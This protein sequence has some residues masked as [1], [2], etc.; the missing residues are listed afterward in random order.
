MFCKLIRGLVCAVTLS[1][2]L[3]GHVLG[4]EVTVNQAVEY[5]TIDGFGAFGARNVNWSDPSTW[6]N[7]YWLDLVINDLGLTIHRNEYYPPGGDQDSSFAEQIAF[8]Q[9]L[10]Q[11]AQD[12]NEPLKFIVAFWSPPAWMKD[13]G[14][15]KN[16]GRVL[17]QYYDDLGNWAVTC[18][19]DY[20]SIGINVYALS[21]QNEPNFTQPYNSCVYSPQEYRDMVKVAG[22]IIKAAFPNVRLYGAEHMLWAMQW[23]ELNYESPIIADTNA[24]PYMGIWAN[25]G[26][27]NDGQTPDPNSAE[28]AAWVGAWNVV[29]NTG[30]PL[31]M[32]E[33][34]GYD[35]TWPNC[36]QLG[37]AIYA[38]LKCGRASG[39]VWWQLGEE[40]VSAYN[41]MNLDT[42]TKRYYV[43]KQYY[44]YV[45]PG[46]VVVESTSDD[47][48]V[49][50]LAF[51]HAAK[52]TA[53]IIL[54]NTAQA[55]RTA[56]LSIAGDILPAQFT[57]YRTSETENCVTVGTVS[58]AGSVVLP[59]KTI[60]T[61]YGTVT[62]TPPEQAHDP[63][64]AD[65]TNGVSIFSQLTWSAG[66]RATSHDVYFGTNATPGLDE[67]QGNQTETTFDTGA[68]DFNTTYYWRIDEKNAYGT[69][70][71]AVW[72]FTTGSTVPPPGQAGNL[73]PADG[74]T[75]VVRTVQLAWTAG[76]YAVSHDVFFGTNFNAVDDANESSDEFMGNQPQPTFNPGTLVKKTTYYWRIDERNDGGTTKGQVW[77]FKTNGDGL[78]IVFDS[79]SS[80]TSGTMGT[81]LSWSHTIDGGMNR[82]LVVG[83][84]SEAQGA[85][86][87]NVTS[88]TYNG[89]AMKPVVGS[90]SIV[91]TDW[92]MKS[93]L[94]YLP[95][96]NL[97]PA[98]TYTI[99]ATYAG[100]VFNRNGG[101]ISLANVEQQLA[102]AATTKVVSDGTAISTNITTLT[103]GAWVVDV[104]G[105]GD[106]GTFSPTSAAMVERYDITAN[107]SS[108]AGSTKSIPMAG[109]TTMSWSHS[110]PKRMAHSLAAFAPEAAGCPIGDLSGDCHVNWDDVDIFCDQWLDAGCSGE[111][112]ADLNGTDG[113]NMADFALLAGVWGK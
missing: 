44:R 48:N 75:S 29:G 78:A 65:D 93:D 8:L 9:A 108:A 82:L 41:L 64:P 11:K 36:M 80:A 96:A 14:S 84:A 111:G 73:S 28:A 33:T 13:N 30:R 42:P 57:I 81:T 2:L 95:D 109:Q 16:G 45:R 31:W 38:A 83:L 19:Q 53:T 55:Q 105:S 100:S 112:C 79:A 21:L 20:N 7:A 94:Y 91:G 110:T 46:A 77:S 90:S 99:T 32:T 27:G 26:Y 88:V 4:A 51:R 56:D 18:L 74:N 60:T 34:S 102:E 87:L 59:A 69:T 47:P 103:D 71:G 3:S 86:D 101:A 104:V 39:W 17:P 10:K 61:L 54:I 76:V 70:A 92:L 66:Y 107:S 68:L 72:S 97:P 24:N 63:G 37:T 35:D 40:G 98:G 67:F 49:F 85:N 22:P 50:V 52:S 5:Q 113:V 25:H 106:L 58:G 12:S 6:Y 15:T 43:S 23:P 62:A 1:V 89:V